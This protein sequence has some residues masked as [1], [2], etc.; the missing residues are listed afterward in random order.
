M[1]RLSVAVAALLAVQFSAAHADV[2]MS[3][4]FQG[5]LTDATGNP[6]T[7]SQTVVFSI[8]DAVSAG[9]QLWSETQSVAVTSGIYNVGLGNVLALS[10]AVFAGGPTWLQLQVGADAAMT[11]RIPFRT[12]AYSFWSQMASG[13]LTKAP[14]NDLFNMTQVNLNLTSSPGYTVPAGKNFI[15]YNVEQKKACVVN[16]ATDCFTYPGPPAQTYCNPT[17]CYIKVTG[18][19]TATNLVKIN[20]TQAPFIIGPGDVITSTASNISIVVQG[21]LVSNRVTVVLQDISPSGTYTN[22]SSSDLY[23][24]LFP[25]QKICTG[26]VNVGGF[27]WPGPGAG[28]Q[29]AAGQTV[30]NNTN[31]TVTLD[32]Y[33]K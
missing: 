19:H 25:S 4:N 27:I 7:G 15:A 14:L 18:A 9:N 30:T 23:F 33:L 31:C 5:R 17:A 29:L 10:T 16:P 32:G 2:P 28:G 21:V 11:P 22:S 6:L 12:T 20:S 13:L 24:G 8:W 26:S 3:M 1:R